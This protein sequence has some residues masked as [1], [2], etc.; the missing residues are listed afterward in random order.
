MAAVRKKTWLRWIQSV[1]FYLFY[2]YD[3]LPDNF[4]MTFGCKAI[5]KLQNPVYLIL[6]NIGQY[7]IM[8]QLQVFVPPLRLSEVSFILT[9]F[10][11]GLFWSLSFS[12]ARV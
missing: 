9:P 7:R 10:I 8:L 3:S 2:R 4:S 5:A 12:V 6:F 11:V 1:L